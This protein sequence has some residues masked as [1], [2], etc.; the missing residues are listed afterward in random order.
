MKKVYKLLNC[1]TTLAYFSF[2]DA[3]KSSEDIIII[4]TESVRFEDVPEN[5]FPFILKKYRDAMKLNTWLNSRAL[6]LRRSNYRSFLRELRLVGRYQLLLCSF[7]LSLNDTFWICD[8]EL[9]IFWEDINLFSH[10][11]SKEMAKLSF[12]SLNDSLGSIDQ[13]NTPELTTGGDLP[14]F[15]DRID[16]KIFLYK[17]GIFEPLNEYLSSKIFEELLIDHVTYSLVRSKQKWLSKCE[18]FTNKETGFLTFM[19]ALSAFNIDSSSYNSESFYTVLLE[20]GYDISTY[21]D[22][23]IGDH[24]IRNVDR[25]LSNFG[26]IY[27]TA[28][29][30][31]LNLAPLFDH[32]AG[33]Y[34]NECVEFL[35]DR[36]NFFYKAFPSDLDLD[37]LLLNALSSNMK[38]R[39]RELH[40]SVFSGNLR[41]ILNLL[42]EKEALTESRRQLIEDWINY[43]INF[44][45]GFKRGDL[46]NKSKEDFNKRVVNLTTLELF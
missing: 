38:D 35:S 2:H 4:D 9:S 18:L 15:W 27:D 13:Y 23:L 14:K 42:V 26:F 17:G 43:I 33:F 34:E 36:Y 25:N 11:F 1:D 31:I 37:G 20:F 16:N 41:N 32:G 10:S 6:S 24:I 7:A 5:K 44:L 46:I 12:D 21:Y 40:R 39:L 29:S 22:M 8:E 30:K 28:T 19:E 45:L 3:Y